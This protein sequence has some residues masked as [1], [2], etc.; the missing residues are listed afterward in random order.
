MSDNDFSSPPAAPAPDP[1]AADQAPAEFLDAHSRRRLAWALGIAGG[2]VLLLL[3]ATYGAYFMRFGDQP[4]GDQGTWGQ[5]GDFVGGTLNSLLGLLT[6]LALVFT[7]VLQTRQLELSRDELRATRDE[8][9]RSTAAQRDAAAAMNGQL[10]QA[11]LTAKAQ[12][13]AADHQLMA[14]MAMQEQAEAARSAAQAQWRAAQIAGLSEG[15]RI[16][17]HQL[18]N[19]P[20]GPYV[21]DERDRISTL[22]LQARE[23]FWR[24]FETV[25][26]GTRPD[27]EQALD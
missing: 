7:V 8:L 2:I 16:A 19:M 5:F 9:A 13:E 11:R 12:A 24:L 17:Q 14:A 18:A 25:I 21:A 10:E 22:E 6:L 1:A 20:T 26:H 23:H 27:D 15:M 4:S 3:A